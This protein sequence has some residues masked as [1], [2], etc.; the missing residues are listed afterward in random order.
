M[1]SRQPEMPNIDD[2]VNRYEGKGEFATDE[3]LQPQETPPGRL[4]S[5]VQ[6]TVSIG[7]N[8]TQ[9]QYGRWDQYRY[10]AQ[11]L[12]VLM[13]EFISVHYLR[14]A[15]RESLEP[16][17]IVRLGIDD[18]VYDTGVD[19]SII[20]PETE[21]PLDFG[22]AVEYVESGGAHQDKYILEKTGVKKLI[23][24]V[25]PLAL[26]G[27]EWFTN[28]DQ[29]FYILPKLREIMPDIDL[30]VRLRANQ[31]TG[32]VRHI[33]DSPS[34]IATVGIAE[35]ADFV[36]TQGLEGVHQFK[37]LKRILELARVET[38]VIPSIDIKKSLDIFNERQIGNFSRRSLEKA[39]I[40][41]DEPLAARLYELA[42]QGEPGTSQ[43]I[44]QI[45]EEYYT[46]MAIGL[47]EVGSG[48]VH[49]NS[50]NHVRTTTRIAKAI[51][52]SF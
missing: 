19:P 49:L 1:S 42:W 8:G 20:V 11:E 48:K 7:V 44:N 28:A 35:Q 3:T 51:I 23:L 41:I 47:A 21:L 36:L 13:P 38:P 37:S 17:P 46:R 26:S 10:A 24:P 52:E 50:N 16:H 45:L 18:V 2:W 22:S 25:N 34:A 43:E 12:S 29:I 5:S 33:D 6:N 40:T 31:D 4:V 14:Q 27:E 9:K 30:G 15:G 39:G 32:Y